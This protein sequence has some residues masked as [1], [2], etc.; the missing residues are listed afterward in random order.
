VLGYWDEL[1]R[2][3]PDDMQARIDDTARRITCPY[4]A[5]V[6]RALAPSERADLGRRG[7]GVQIEEWPDSGHCVHLVELDRFTSR[8]RAFINSCTPKAE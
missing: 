3:D 7:A 1:R 4:L 5:V 2:T 6:G 8:L